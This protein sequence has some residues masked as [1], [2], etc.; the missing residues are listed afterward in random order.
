MRLR[1]GTLGRYLDRKNKTEFFLKKKRDETKQGES[2]TKHIFVDIP[3][4]GKPTEVLGKR[5]I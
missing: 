5:L 2:K 4:V 1:Y 3:Y